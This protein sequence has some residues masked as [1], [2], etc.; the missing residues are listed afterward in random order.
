MSSREIHIVRTLDEARW[1]EFVDHHP[2]AHIF[3]TPEI[4]KA[5]QRAKGY[6]PNL[7]ATVDSVGEI[8]ALLLP[9]SITILDR[10]F[11]HLT[12][13][14]VVYGGPLC[15][16]GKVGRE[17]LSVLLHQ[18]NQEVQ[19]S[20]LFTELRNLSDLDEFQPVLKLRGFS[21]EDHLNFLIDLSQPL[22]VIWGN[23]H[24][25]ARRNIKKARKSKVEIEE[26]DHSSDIFTAYHLL[27][28]VYSRIH[29]P[30]PDLSFF[31]ASFNALHPF[32]MLKILLAKVNDIPIG[33]LNLLTYKGIIYYW[34][35]GTLR[36]YSQYRAADLLVWRALELGKNN[37]LQIFDFGGAGK[38]GERYGVRDFKAKFGGRLVN[39]GRNI[40]IHA[41]L[42][43]KISQAG[44]QLMRRFL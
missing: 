11:L 42:R 35:T 25:N 43:L 15:V 18:Y 36:D 29:V 40:C 34:Y 14:A 16:P 44:Y 26:L 9:V 32:G 8:L 17:A 27:R 37:G 7:W 2:R 39:Y 19:N 1:R 28:K 13:R 21:Y 33:V 38:P 6:Q 3:H 4:Y 24:S 31:Q 23:I 10:L 22:D 30:L 12:T 5:F 20:V 41:P